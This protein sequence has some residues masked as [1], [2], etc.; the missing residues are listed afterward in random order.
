VPLEI[1][2][3]PVVHRRK[4]AALSDPVEQSTA[5]EHLP[6][7]IL[8]LGKQDLDVGFFRLGNQAQKRI[9]GRQ[10]NSKIGMKIDEN[11][12]GRDAA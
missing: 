2:L 6:H 7:G 5:P 10:I 12:L 8:K 11:G 4:E 3:H 9:G 1:I